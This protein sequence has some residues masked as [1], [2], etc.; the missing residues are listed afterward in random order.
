ML[1]R[2]AFRTTSCWRRKTVSAS[3]AA[4][5]Q[6]SQTSNPL[7][8]FKEV[9]HPTARIARRG[10]CAIPDTIFGTHRVDKPPPFTGYLGG[11]VPPGAGIAVP[12]GGVPVGI[13]VVAVPAGW[14]CAAAGVPPRRS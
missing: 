9:K 2:T 13:P 5:D 11:A 3:R 10:I 7:S 14:P 8:S 4:C 12:A 6:N 1:A